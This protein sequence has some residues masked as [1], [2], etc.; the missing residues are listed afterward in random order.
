MMEI[1]KSAFL[2]SDI[3]LSLFS[4]TLIVFFGRMEI[5]ILRKYLLTLKIA[6]YRKM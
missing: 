2:N 1:Q 6:I 5:F 4:E 3:E